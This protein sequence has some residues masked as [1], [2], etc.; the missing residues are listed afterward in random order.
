V[1]LPGEPA[2]TQAAEV[3]NEDGSTVFGRAA[4]LAPPDHPPLRSLPLPAVTPIAGPSLIPM[5][6]PYASHF[7]LLHHVSESSIDL[8]QEAFSER[9]VRDQDLPALQSF[10]APGGSL[11]TTFES[12]GYLVQAPD[13]SRGLGDAWQVPEPMRP[14]LRQELSRYIAAFVRSEGI[15][16][17]NSVDELSRV[18]HG[19]L[20]DVLEARA[21]DSADGERWFGELAVQL[22]RAER[23][24]SLEQLWYRMNLRLLVT[25][26]V[27][28]YETFSTIPESVLDSY[29]GLRFAQTYVASTAIMFRAAPAAADDDVNAL[30]ARLSLQITEI[31]AAVG[32]GWRSLTTIDACLHVGLNWMRYL[33]LRGEFAAALDVL[34]ELRAYLR[35]EVAAGQRVSDRN[36]S[37]MKLEQGILFLFME[38]Y[39]DAAESLRECTLL[40]QRPVAG[41]YVPAFAHALSALIHALMGSAQS[42]QVS[43]DRSHAIFGEV[44]DYHYVSVLTATVQSMLALDRLDLPRAASFIHELDSLA[45]E[46]ELWA[47]ATATAQRVDLASARGADIVG[48]LDALNHTAAGVSRLSPFARNIYVC[49][50]IDAAQALGNVQ[51]ARDITQRI[52]TPSASVRVAEVRMNL[53]ADRVERALNL[54]KAVE[55]DEGLLGPDRAGLAL[56]EAVAHDRLGHAVEARAALELA[57]R[58]MTSM[59]SAMPV[60]FVTRG[61]RVQLMAMIIEP[62]LWQQWAAAVQLTEHELRARIDGVAQIFADTA[63]LVDLSA[64]EMRVLALIDSGATQA[65]IAQQLNLS[66]S[67]VKK[68]VAG[69][70]R[71]LGA[72]SRTDALRRAYELRLLEGTRL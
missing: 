16:A 71:S 45:P 44:N 55:H 33:R 8:L 57:V 43:L 7:L 3:N 24:Q 56:L 30:V 23:W 31:T 69:L 40:W 29:A 65:E 22:R 41:D 13:I 66:L 32:P 60:C 68:Q 38:R 34:D 10:A 2:F 58:R 20:A 15:D 28:T 59:R 25:Y 72:E 51:L 11:L 35:S 50:R 19:R 6:I 9:L 4:Q 1:S 17:S 37:F 53:M 47:I 18:A 26:P 39:G 48:R 49:A 42:A 52:A 14:L 27:E 54:A 46:S 21:A 64:R 36:V 61:M 70:Y 63:V 12:V 62:E 67:A 5:L